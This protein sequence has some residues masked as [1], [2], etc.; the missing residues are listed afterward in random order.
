MARTGRIDRLMQPLEPTNANADADAACVVAELHLTSP[1]SV[2]L[3]LDSV[4]SAAAGIPFSYLE[5]GVRGLKPVSDPN[6]C[7]TLVFV[8][9]RL[10]FNSSA[11]SP[12]HILAYKY[13][14]IGEGDPSRFLF[15][16]RCVFRARYL[17]TF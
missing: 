2:P 3:E 6:L 1:T 12:A 8:P 15:G 10:F 5:F 14:V 16:L 9:W 17:S 13:V 4:S 7:G 11:A